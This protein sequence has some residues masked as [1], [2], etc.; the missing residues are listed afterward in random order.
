MNHDLAAG[1]S[2]HGCRLVREVGCPPLDAVAATGLARNRDDV[3]VYAQPIDE[4]SADDAGCTENG[5]PHRDLRAM[6][7]R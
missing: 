6:R 4:G 1:E 5:D 2:M 7:S 3:V